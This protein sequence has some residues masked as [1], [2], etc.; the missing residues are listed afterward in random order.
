V[1]RYDDLVGRYLPQGEV[2]AYVIDPKLVRVRAVVDQAAI[3]LVRKQTASIDLR[4]FSEVGEIIQ[5]NIHHEVPAATDQLPSAAL[6]TQFG[7]PFPV[8]PGDEQY[9]RTL[10]KVFQIDLLP[11]THLP[12]NVIGTRVKVRFSHGNEPVGFRVY[13]LTRQ[14]LLR[15]FNA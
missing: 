4:L 9:L 10:Q 8:E 12:V 11:A 7:G 6:S 15:K 13:R 2:L 3:G 1:P 14:L 5:A